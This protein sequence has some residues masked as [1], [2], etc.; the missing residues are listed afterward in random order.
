MLIWRSLPDRKA[1]EGRRLLETPDSMERKNQV[2]GG[3]KHV[4]D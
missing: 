4:S 2:K 3:K 1:G